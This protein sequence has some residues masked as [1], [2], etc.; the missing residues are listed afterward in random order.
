MRG[1]AAYTSGS[2]RVPSSAA[3]LKGKLVGE[4]RT[5]V[6]TV[7]EDPALL[8]LG[9]QIDPLLNAWRSAAQ[10]ELEAC[11][12]AENLS[13]PLPDELVRKPEDRITFAA[14]A[15]DEK[16]VLGN[17][18]WPPNYV[19]SDGKT[20][21]RPARQILK[22][23]LIEK[24]IERGTLNGSRRTKLGKRVHRLI[25][26]AKRYEAGRKAAIKR[27]G[28]EAAEDGARWAS[29]DVLKLV[30]EMGKIDALTRGGVL[31]QARAFVSWCEVEPGHGP[32]IVPLAH[33][34]AVSMLRIAARG[35]S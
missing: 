23:A 19:G 17:V 21:G 6:E 34:L 8:E 29:G 26:I 11:A 4:A 25:A 22:A 13:P 31:I 33:N 14:C 32:R 27:S 7:A 30:C 18:I 3:T 28:I 10:R 20:Y 9:A 15:E 2:E 5:S 1:R 35:V 24:A 16:D 12:T